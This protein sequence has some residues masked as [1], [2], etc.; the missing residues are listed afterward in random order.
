MEAGGDV[1][2]GG[3]GGAYDCSCAVALGRETVKLKWL[4][5]ALCAAFGLLEV[6]VLCGKVLVF[7]CFF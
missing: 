1:P 6:M 7:Q 3:W 4:E 2:R 5:R